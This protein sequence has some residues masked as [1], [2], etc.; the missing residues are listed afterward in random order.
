M[1]RPVT[2]AD[3]DMFVA[4]CREFYHSP[5]V[6]APIP[7]EYIENTFR[8]LCSPRPLAEAYFFI[9]DDRPV[10]YC[11]LANAFSTE[12]GGRVQ[13]IEEIYV[14][15]AY[16]GRGIG[17]E[18]FT[19]LEAHRSPDVKR[20]RLEVEPDNEAA[21]RLYKKM[22]FQPLPYQQMVRDYD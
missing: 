10:G 22:G 14:R 3:H 19:Y 4:L 18:F 16:Q 5:A 9:V 6:L 2:P 12:A 21:K 20:F 17:H 7:D 13:W 11:L 1:L 8:E 15:P